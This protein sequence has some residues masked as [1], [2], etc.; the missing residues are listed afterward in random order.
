MNVSPPF[1]PLPRRVLTFPI[2]HQMWMKIFTSVLWV[3]DDKPVKAFLCAILL[4]PL[5]HLVD[6]VKPRRSLYDL[7][8]VSA[9]RHGF[10]PKRRAVP[11]A[12]SLRLVLRHLMK[13][14]KNKQIFW[15]CLKTW[16]PQITANVSS[17][18]TD[19][20]LRANRTLWTKN[21]QP[22]KCVNFNQTSCFT[23]VC[24]CVCV[25]K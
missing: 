13:K 11:R 1:R 24:V 12:R 8:S 10:S 21:S 15:G 22:I 6:F 17:L 18:R 14:K 16:S 7:I 4:P 23:R 20:F 3:S 2:S 5:P 25:C 19:S 9:A